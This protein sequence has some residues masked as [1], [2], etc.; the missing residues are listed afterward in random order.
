M[1][2][3]KNNS[4]SDLRIAACVYATA[5]RIMCNR[6]GQNGAKEI[7]KEEETAIVGTRDDI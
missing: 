7:L 2:E 4:Q 1:N 6:P 5:A 3:D